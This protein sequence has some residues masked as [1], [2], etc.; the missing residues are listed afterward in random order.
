MGKTIIS[1]FHDLE[2]IKYISDRVVLLKNGEILKDGEVND[3]LTKENL[4]QL[5]EENLI[6]FF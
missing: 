5:F 3:V 6:Q 1:V 4:T 2:S